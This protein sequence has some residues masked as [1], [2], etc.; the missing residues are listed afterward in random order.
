MQTAQEINLAQMKEVDLHT[1]DRE[2]LA[3]IRDVRVDEE[4]PRKQRFEDYLRQIKNPYCYRCG[5]MV[6]KVSFS[7]T[8][9]TL[10][11]RLEHYLATMQ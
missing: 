6:V 3:D 8:E 1:V 11:D 4:L 2:S 7:D 10:E 9:A 5:K